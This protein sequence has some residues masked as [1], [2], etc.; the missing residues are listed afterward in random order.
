MYDIFRRNTTRNEWSKYMR[1]LTSEKWDEDDCDSN[2]LDDVVKLVLGAVSKMVV[3]CRSIKT[4]CV[5]TSKFVLEME[6][7]VKIIMRDI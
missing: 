3:V 2:C 7:D 5:L 6:P 1:T 4:F